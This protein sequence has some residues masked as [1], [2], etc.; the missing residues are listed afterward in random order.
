[1]LERMT[2]KTTSNRSHLHVVREVE[3]IGG[4]VLTSAARE[5]MGYT[6]NAL[7]SYVPKMVELKN[8]TASRIILA[9]SGVEHE[10]LLSIAEPL[11][12]DLPRC[13]PHQEPKSVYNG[14]DYRHQGDSEDARTH[15]ALAF[16]LPSDW[17]KEK[18]A[19]ALM[20]LQVLTMNIL[21]LSDFH[22]NLVYVALSI[23]V[24]ALF[25]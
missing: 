15:F 21:W 25:G 7:K 22:D 18:D 12:S 1:M 14:G 9:A 6:F 24:G 23:S 8:Y 20:V 3:A 4:T 17:R 10:E 16:E 19:M 2:F 5:Q 13:V 11:L